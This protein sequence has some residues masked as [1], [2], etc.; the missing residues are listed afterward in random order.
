[1]KRWA[2]GV[3]PFIGLTLILLTS[4]KL[5]SDA[6]ED[7]A[8]FGRLYA[9][10]VIVNLVGLVVLAGLL[11][12][13]LIALLG[14]LRARVPGSRLT[15]RMVAMFVVISGTPVLTV[16]FFSL[17]FLLRGIDSWFDVRVERALHDALEL[18][19]AALDSRMRELLRQSE[20]IASELGGI[21]GDQLPGRLD[22]EREVA[23]AGELTV[24]SAQ[25]RIIAS[26]SSDTSRILPHAPEEA[27]LLQVRQTGTYVGLDPTGNSGLVIRVVVRIPEL[28]ATHQT[29]IL[30]AL[31]PVA[32]R[33]RDLAASVESA[34]AHY[35]ELVYLRGP[36]KASFVLTLSLVLLLSLLGALWAA[37]FSA[38]RLA[39]PI[40]D[41][42]EGTR[43]VAEGDYETKLPQMTQDEM[44]FLVRSFN[45][46]TGRLARARDEA[47]QS[48]QAVE[49]QRQYLQAVLA[50]LSSGVVTVD[51]ESRVCTA[52]AA[53][54]TILGVDLAAQ[55]GRPVAEIRASHPHLAPLHDAFALHLTTGTADWREEVS[56]F[57]PKGR[58]V[59]MCRGTP[60]SSL[61]EHVIVFDDVTALIQAQRDAAWSEVARRLAHEIK[62][63][64]TPIQLSAE[65][66]RHKYLDKMQD[67]DREVLDRLTHTIIQQVEAMKEMVNAFSSYARSPQM[68]LEHV[69][70]NDLVREVVEL[71]RYN[72]GETQVETSL[73]EHAPPVEGDT[74]RLRQVLHNL[75]KNALEACAG[76]PQCKVTVTTRF[77]EERG[78]RY[79]ELA[80]EDNGPGFA[81]EVL[82][83]IFEPYVTTKS[84]GTGLGLAIVKKI[85]EEHG[86]VVRAEGRQ[87]GGARV[88][89]RLPAQPATDRGTQEAKEAG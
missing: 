30:Q 68:R 61:G 29:R 50:R 74:G 47:R 83:H 66:L 88:W 56:L 7:S 70:L 23:G 79:I 44:G 72:R 87:A 21:P 26:S 4:L 12:A 89:L 3:T 69:G 80:T 36:L 14:Q 45:E 41:L 81:P 19:R 51:A 76:N 37:F 48:Q 49:E 84:R 5:M 82:A 39:A 10:L 64:L 16:Y 40:R 6:S 28:V 77:V 1:M 65:R 75:L 86:G 35:R 42:A 9:L 31:F 43:A 8:A 11:A 13:N 71:Y 22:D 58:Q 73:D 78:T 62:N 55:V 34:F 60:L 59:L 24:A 63:P 46:M 18:S 2:T 33:I 20:L 27:V 38:R 15:A 85:V 52:N 53:A 67:R 25:G 32:A 57:G 17:Q 54:G